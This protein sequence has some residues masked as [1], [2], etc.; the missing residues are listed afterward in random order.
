MVDVV[1]CLDWVG[2]GLGYAVGA[3]DVD[4]FAVP[5]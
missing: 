1:V 3:F 4:E 5:S 2:V